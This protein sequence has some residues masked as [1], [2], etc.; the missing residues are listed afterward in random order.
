MCLMT[1]SVSTY[2]DDLNLALT[3]ADA[4]DTITMTRFEASDLSVESKPDLTPVSDADTAVEK[5]LREIIAAHYPDDALLGEEFGG[6]VTFAGRQWVIDPI[7]G[8][9]NF[10]RGVP[11]WATLISLLVDG[12]PV[13][14][15]V[16]APA[17]GRRWWAA[18]G[19]G[20]WR[21]FNTPASTGTS[22]DAA[23]ANGGSVDGGVPSAGARQL[24]VSKV[25]DVADSSI[26]TSSLSGWADCGKREQLISLTDSAWRL[27]GYGDFWSY[28]LVAEGA[29]DIAA[30][31]EVSLWD[32]AALVPIITEAG[33]RFTS[34]DGQ[35]GPHGG[36]AVAT[37]GLL[38]EATLSALA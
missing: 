19:A 33:G 24:G 10:V 28:M 29:V 34:L 36:S 32:L 22:A 11:V 23:P 20:A 26:A 7:D 17:L 25:A 9:K 13:V 35:D 3:L 1:D 27:R 15:V 14:G 38:H 6:D 37:N 5:E 21:L 4:A 31:P 30:E 12:K 2:A 18:E 16:S 8:T